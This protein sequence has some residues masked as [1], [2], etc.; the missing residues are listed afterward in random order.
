VERTGGYGLAI[1]DT[2]FHEYGYRQMYTR[3]KPDAATGNYA[4]RL[5][6]DTNRQTKGLLHDEAMALL[7]E[8][9]HGI[10]AVRLSDRWRPTSA[11][12][13]GGPV[14]CPARAQICFSRG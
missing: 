8:G 10:Q 4:D 2:L 9:T 1:I 7:R 11:R 12:A 3:R 14:R 13:P 6:W 5:G